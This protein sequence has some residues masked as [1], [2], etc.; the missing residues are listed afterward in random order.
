MS[1]CFILLYIC[2]HGVNTDEMK[3]VTEGDSVTLHTD[4]TEIQK[5]DQLFWR[6]GPKDARIAEI[7]K[8]SH[9]IYDDTNGIFK[10]KLQL[11]T[12]TGSLT[13]TNVSITQTGVYKLTIIN[14]KGNSYKTLGVSVYGVYTDEVK[15]VSVMEG[16]SVTLH[17]DLTELQRDDQI[18]WMF[19]P[20][21]GRIAQIYKQSAPIYNTNGRFRDKLKLDNQTGSLTITNIINEQ[22][23]VYKVAIISSKGNLYK[24][25]RVSVYAGLPIPVITRNS[26]NCSS[27]SSVSKCVLLCSV[28][29][30]RDVSLSWYKGNSLLSSISV[31]DLNIRLSLSLEVEYQDTNTYRCVL[32]NTITN[33]TQHLN[34]THLCQTSSDIVPHSYY[35]NTETVIRL[36]VS[37]LMGVAA[38]AAVVVLIYDIRSRRAEQKR[39]HQTSVKH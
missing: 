4:L 27:S 37:A 29:N 23:G 14:S 7:Y 5:D 13:I 34:I 9:P 20:K 36:V 18:V 3:S 33:Q 22:A 1:L 15:S 35:G 17:T 10:D 38:A 19:G 39:R 32:N 30:V 31:S 16:D 21:N 24:T 2:M 28:L 6:F 26:S 25:F 12:H 11:D 8:Q